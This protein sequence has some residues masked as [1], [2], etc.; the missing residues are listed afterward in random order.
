MLDEWRSRAPAPLKTEPKLRNPIRLVAPD[1]LI[2]LQS[3][4]GGPQ[5]LS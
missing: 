3:G 1:E 5:R 4:V 2:T